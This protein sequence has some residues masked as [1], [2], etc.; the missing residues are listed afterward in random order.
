M[1]AGPPRSA[2]AVA[3]AAAPATIIYAEQ[4]QQDE[5]DDD[6][7]VD[8]VGDYRPPRGL[9]PSPSSQPTR[10]SSTPTQPLSLSSSCPPIISP[11]TAIPQPAINAPSVWHVPQWVQ[12]S[13]Q[14]LAAAAAASTSGA[15]KSVPLS[16][17]SASFL[18]PSSVSPQAHASVSQSGHAASVFTAAAAAAAGANAAAGT[19]LPPGAISATPQQHWTP[20]PTIVPWPS[21]AEF[22]KVVAGPGAA[23]APSAVSGGAYQPQAGVWPV[24]FRGAAIRVPYILASPGASTSVLP[25]EQQSPGPNNHSH[26]VAAAAVAS[27]GMGHVIAIER[28]SAQNSRQA[29]LQSLATSSQS[30]H[31]ANMS[32]NMVVPQAQHPK[33]R[34]PGESSTHPDGGD[35]PIADEGPDEDEPQERFSEE[36]LVTK[37]QHSTRDLHSNYT[38]LNKEPSAISSN[39]GSRSPTSHGS[40]SEGPQD[41]RKRMIEK[42]HKPKAESSGIVMG[43]SGSA[44]TSVVSAHNPVAKTIT[45]SAAH[46]PHHV[47]SVVMFSP[48]QSTVVPNQVA[49]PNPAAL[50]LV[51]VNVPHFG[52]TGLR[53]SYVQ[54]AVQPSN[55]PIGSRKILPGPPKS[56]CGPLRLPS[57]SVDKPASPER[58]RCS[59]C[60]TLA[61]G[62]RSALT[63]R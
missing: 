36:E 57:F 37:N 45:V 33:A 53:D 4:Q 14:Y 23:N 30:Q 8:V 58:T 50:P 40:R 22:C 61:C 27:P 15:T 20:Y 59:I 19:F 16:P 7:E 41:F 12:P 2:R 21:G 39:T 13:P 31:H 35:N 17:A 10:P 60:G 52:A 34:H 46:Q 47:S 51:G 49:K 43:G 54:A 44:F 9:L 6:R 48:A 56:T 29:A 28:E 55:V 18:P 5:A 11:M 63:I 26:P 1:D 32:S 62:S 42:W 24:D 3:A 25:G 38:T